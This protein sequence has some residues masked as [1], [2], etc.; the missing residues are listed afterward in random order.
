MQ[1]DDKFRRDLPC[2]IMDRIN[3]ILQARLLVIRKR[4]GVLVPSAVVTVCHFIFCFLRSWDPLSIVWEGKLIAGHATVLS[5]RGR[6]GER[7]GRGS[8]E[9][10]DVPRK[11]SNSKRSLRAIVC[12]RT[13]GSGASLSKQSLPAIQDFVAV[14]VF[15][16][17]Q[18]A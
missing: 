5:S 10:Q 4:P 13:C 16:A 17:E 9:C 6:L 2:G 12:S 1:R 8:D 11:M 7:R 15:W 14:S 18:S 3:E